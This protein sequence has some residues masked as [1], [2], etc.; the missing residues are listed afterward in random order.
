MRPLAAWL[1]IL[2]ALVVGIFAGS[3]VVRATTGSGI[4]LI[5]PC[6][7]LAEAEK[8]GHLDAQKRAALIDRVAQSAA[9]SARDKDDAAK[10]RT[11]CPKF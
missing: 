11:Q 9:L 2:G 6:F 3:Y 5:L 4:A 7:F 8:A 1:V 10:L